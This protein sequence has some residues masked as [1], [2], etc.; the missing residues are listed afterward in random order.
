MDTSVLQ[1]GEAG[2][3]RKH[4][5]R[6][7]SWT[8]PKLPSTRTARR[9]DT[10]AVPPRNAPS[11]KIGSETVSR[12]ILGADTCHGRCRQVPGSLVEAHGNTHTHPHTHT[13]TMGTANENKARKR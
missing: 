11:Q 7:C 9:R 3:H 12:I 13:H 10:W 8:L 4:Q 6:S 5:S 1:A 2:Q